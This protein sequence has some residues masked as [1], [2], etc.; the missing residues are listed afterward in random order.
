MTEAKAFPTCQYLH[1]I[2]PDDFI[3][4]WVEL[5]LHLDISLPLFRDLHL[6]DSKLGSSKI[7]RKELSIFYEERKTVTI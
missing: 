7:Q 4:C 2:P 6:E 3:G 5:T 1:A